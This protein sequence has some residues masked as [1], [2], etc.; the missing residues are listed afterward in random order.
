MT[1]LDGLGVVSRSFHQL[2]S[3]GSLYANLDLDTLFKAQKQGKGL[4]AYQVSRWIAQAT[5]NGSDDWIHSFSCSWIPHLDMG[6]LRQLLDVSQGHGVKDFGIRQIVLRGY[7]W[8]KDWAFFKTPMHAHHF[9]KLRVLNLSFIKELPTRV[10]LHWCMEAPRL[11]VLC[12]NHSFDERNPFSLS[13]DAETVKSL[14]SCTLLSKTYL[15]L[16]SGACFTHTQ[17]TRLELRECRIDSAYSVLN[18]FHSFPSLTHLDLA[19]S[20]IQCDKDIVAAFAEKMVQERRDRCRL[21][22]FIAAQCHWLTHYARLRACIWLLIRPSVRVCNL[23][24]IERM[25]DVFFASLLEAQRPS[26]AAAAA[27]AAALPCRLRYLILDDC[28]R[29]G[30][31]SFVTMGTLF[32]ADLTHLSL[33][34]HFGMNESELLNLVSMCRKLVW[35]NI[36]DCRLLS[37][38]FFRSILAIERDATLVLEAFDCHAML[39]PVSEIMKRM[40]PVQRGV[41]SMALADSVRPL[42]LLS[43]TWS[44][45]TS[46]H[47]F[48]YLQDV[49]DGSDTI[50]GSF[51]RRELRYQLQLKCLFSLGVDLFLFAVLDKVFLYV[52]SE[53]YRVHLR[54][55][56]QDGI[57]ISGIQESANLF[58]YQ[59]NI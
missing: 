16:Q 44:S 35:L 13:C 57:W 38:Q 47:F 37:P 30:S 6:L 59:L 31:G 41:V 3:D 55:K 20:S 24:G 26:L 28:P 54:I 58:A 19:K 36:S 34:Y 25:S 21:R 50:I 17:L 52:D 49:Q 14:H 8:Q 4:C 10:P 1:E 9:P 53:D 56:S 27:A 11:Q 15:G 5:K 48:S 23:S 39:K 2:S 18:I 43:L 12:L 33:E 46:G 7:V 45:V 22:C 32:S 51:R 40:T 42:E 29:L